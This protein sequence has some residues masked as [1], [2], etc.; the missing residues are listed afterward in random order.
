M[1]PILAHGQNGEVAAAKRLWLAHPLFEPILANERC[2]QRFRHIVENYSGW[3]WVNQGL[4]QIPNPPAAERLGAVHAPILVVIGERD[5]PDFH[6]IADFLQDN[7][8]HARKVE[9]AGAGHMSSME[10]PDRFNEI[11]LAYLR[12]EQP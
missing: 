3:H 11:V 8:P 10:A 6:A 1:A 7:V 9:L 2:S 5:L 4:E 12:E